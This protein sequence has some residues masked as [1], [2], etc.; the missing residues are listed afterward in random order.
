MTRNL[1]ELQKELP[2][3]SGL[4]LLL[5]TADPD[6]DTPPV[7]R[8]YGQRFGADFTRWDF[9][10]GPQLRIYTLATQQLLLAVAEN[11]NP[12]DAAPQDLF[13]HS[14]KLVLVDAQGR[15]RAAYD[16]EDPAARDQVL[17]DLHR[18]ETEPP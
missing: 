9:L 18:L 4:R 3:G 11:P 7:L 10:T 5:L 2:P 13:V 1:A 8:E 15:V 17:A 14:T 6:Y 12:A 16:G